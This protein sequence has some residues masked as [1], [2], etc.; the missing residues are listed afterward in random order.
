MTAKNY[1]PAKVGVTIGSKPLHGFAKGTFVKV[2]RDEDGFSLL[3]G[4]DGESTRAKSNNK[5]GKVVVTLLASSDSNDYLST[6]Q[7]T[8]EVTGLAPFPILIKDNQ[9]N[10]LYTAATA[11]VVKPADAEF[12]Q[13]AA[14]REW[15]FQT[16][17][18]VAFAG[19]NTV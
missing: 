9:G 10:S 18:L 15:T 7:A 3:V 2:S 5:A 12:G 16:D 13:E 19:G 4:A 8:D 14:T 6:L 11:W 17:E 1:N